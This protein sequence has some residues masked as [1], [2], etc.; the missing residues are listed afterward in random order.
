[1]RRRNPS[2]YYPKERGGSGGAG[3]IEID[4]GNFRSRG[5]R[6]VGRGGLR[7]TRA[8]KQLTRLSEAHAEQDK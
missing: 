1:M 7:R 6:N 5:H 8:R 3:L 2:G 4:E